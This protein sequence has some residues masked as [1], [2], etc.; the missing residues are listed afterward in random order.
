MSEEETLFA[1]ETLAKTLDVE[2]RYEKGDFSGGLCRLD[3]KVIL[4]VQKND[5]PHRKISILARELGAFNLDHIFVV[6]A[7][8]DLIAQETAASRPVSGQ[9]TA[10]SNS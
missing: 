9:D 3:E 1:L 7:L 4:L 10:G 6:P 5:P 8:R 2:V